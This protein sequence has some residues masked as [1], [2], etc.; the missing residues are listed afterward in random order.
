MLRLA[1]ITATASALIAPAALAQ[2]AGHGQHSQQA[3]TG[4]AAVFQGWDTDHDGALTLAEF[5][6]GRHPGHQGTGPDPRHNPEHFRELDSDGDGR[7]TLAEFE[8]HH[9]AEQQQGAHANH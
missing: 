4:P 2:H 7:V 8:A 1:A 3:H 5:Q 6:A 9:R